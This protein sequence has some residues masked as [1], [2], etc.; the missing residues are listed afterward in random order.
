MG[1]STVA[2]Y[3]KGRGEF[4]IDTDQLARELVSPGEPALLEIVQLFGN[5][6]LLRD[7]ALDRAAL[8]K[9]VF[10]DRDK[11]K[12]LEAILHP[13]IRNAWRLRLDEQA[14]QGRRR[15]VVVIPLLF[16]TGAETE[17]NTVICVACSSKS[18]VFRLRSRGWNDEEIQ[19]RCAAQKPVREKMDLSQR[20][21]WSEF[22]RDI[23]ELQV[24]QI[25]R[26]S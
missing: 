24:D 3:L 19:R 2:E 21:V 1:K 17:L 11:L 15:A 6:V 14:V 20:V 26:A 7:G 13:R 9:I 5:S 23:T 12:A 18:Q 10:A 16:E 25:F 8:G 22:S 4:V